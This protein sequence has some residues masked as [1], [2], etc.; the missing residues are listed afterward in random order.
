MPDQ[1][2]YL[3][4][5]GYPGG[6]SFNI[7]AF[8]MPQDQTK[9]GDLGRNLLRGV[10]AW[11]ADVALHQ[12]FRLVE[13]ST[14]QF[15]AEAFNVFNHPNFA[16]PSPGSIPQQDIASGAGFGVSQVSLAAGLS[17]PGT[18]GQLNQLFQVGGPRSLQLALRLTF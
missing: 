7:A 1:P 17:P 12:E 9:D 6:K 2:L 15:R 11:Q 4:G 10:G 8:T 14:V 3:Y 13:H 5:S 18:L 16:N